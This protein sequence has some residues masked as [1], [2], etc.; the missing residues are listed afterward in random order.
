[1]FGGQVSVPT[2]LE[3]KNGTTACFLP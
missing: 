2:M 3:A 1:M